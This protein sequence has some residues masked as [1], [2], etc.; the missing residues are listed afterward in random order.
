MASDLMVFYGT[1]RVPQEVPFK[2]AQCG[3]KDLTTAV[4]SL[5][6][7]PESPLQEYPTVVWRPYRG[8]R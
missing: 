7:A 8:P 6:P 4:H 5:Q 2:C 3:S 1:Y